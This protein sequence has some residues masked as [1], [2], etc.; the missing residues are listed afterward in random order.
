MGKT[1]F[2]RGLP[3]S[4]ASSE[5]LEFAQAGSEG[6]EETVWYELAMMFESVKKAQTTILHACFLFIH[7]K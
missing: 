3:N 1:P 7:W 4:R 5:E 6:T 2:L